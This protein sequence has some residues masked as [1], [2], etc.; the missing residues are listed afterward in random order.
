[1][2]QVAAPAQA[3]RVDVAVVVGSIDDYAIDHPTTAVL[4][5]EVADD[6]VFDDVTTQAELYASAGIADYWIVRR[7]GLTKRALKLQGRE[8]AAMYPRCT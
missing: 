3:L 1:M 7:G 4:V 8:L 5:V 2:A 6:T